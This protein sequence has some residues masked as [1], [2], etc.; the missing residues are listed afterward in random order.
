MIDKINGNGSYDLSSNNSKNKRKNPAV[1]AY[2]STPGSKDAAHKRAAEI[3][4]KSSSSK[5]QEDAGVILDLSGKAAGKKK[6]AEAA[7]QKK[8]SF[9]SDTLRR[10][11]HPLVRWLKDFWGSGR[12]EEDVK[13]SDPAE[14]NARA[15]EASE[16]AE[17]GAR[18][19]EVSENAETG[20]RIEEASESAEAGARAEEVSENADLGPAVGGLPLLDDAGMDE[21]ETDEWKAFADKAV[22]SG[23]LQ[24]IE[25]Y[26]TRNGA[27]RL[28]HHS[29]LLTYYDRR[30][31]IV[32]MDVTEKH[33]VLFGDKNVLKL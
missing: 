5:D 21:L 6:E 30:G 9:W 33:R 16:S 19:E 1:R 24:Q 4:K 15:E 23:N 11:V 10:L 26:V 17:T 29:D 22:K 25:Q 27:K 28:A 31:K 18:A 32:E 8:G 2:E 20:A 14:A 3:H 7:R 12:P 13:A